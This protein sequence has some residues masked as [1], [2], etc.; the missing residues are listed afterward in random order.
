[1]LNKTSKITTLIVCFYFLASSLA[2]SHGYDDDRDGPRRRKPHF[3]RG[4][5]FGNPER[6]KKKLDLTDE[7]IEKI[8]KINGE[9]KTK[10]LSGRSNRLSL[11]VFFKKLSNAK[12]CN[13]IPAVQN[14]YAKSA[15][16]IPARICAHV[17]QATSSILL[18]RLAPMKAVQ[19]RSTSPT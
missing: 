7:Q 6:M 9:F 18:K 4:M 8:K 17:I 5:F 16:I 1:M 3:K 14:F 13:L 12:G 15:P 11:T 2:F 10:F 19:S